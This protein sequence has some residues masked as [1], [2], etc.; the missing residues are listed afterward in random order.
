MVSR[1]GI[2]SLQR[3]K[4][5]ELREVLHY[6][7]VNVFPTVPEIRTKEEFLGARIP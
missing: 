4:L 2:R 6:D 1:G 7:H 5:V 3:V